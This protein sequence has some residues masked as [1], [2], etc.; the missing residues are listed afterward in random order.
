MPYKN[1]KLPSPLR[2]QAFSWPTC[3]NWSMLAMLC[4]FVAHRRHTVCMHP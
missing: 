4:A 1:L 3:I 2:L